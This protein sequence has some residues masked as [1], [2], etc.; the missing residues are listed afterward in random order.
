MSQENVEIVRRM[1]ESFARGDFA[2]T[3]SFLHPAIEFSQPATEPGAGTYHGHA[4]VNEAMRK[5]AGAWDDYRVVAE[6]LTDFGDHVLA[7][8]RH[9][10]RGKGSGVDVQQQIF[11]LLTVRDGK[12]ARMRMYYEETEAL[13]A[14][15]LRE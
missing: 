2:G 14:A 4:G 8:T 12:I 3:F 7:R 1:Y 9:Y 11:Q 5:W 6:E 13:E 10:G 15:G